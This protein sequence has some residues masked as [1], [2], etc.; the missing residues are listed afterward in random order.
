MYEKPEL[1]RVGEAQDVILGVF[2]T[3]GDLDLNI[4][5]EDFEYADDGDV[6]LRRPTAG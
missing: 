2:P 3:G 1:N 5:I 4:I 6:D